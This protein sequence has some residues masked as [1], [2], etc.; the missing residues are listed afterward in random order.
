M[1]AMSLTRLSLSRH[2]LWRARKHKNNSSVASDSPR[3]DVRTERNSVHLRQ[4]KEF[5]ADADFGALA[6]RVA[7]VNSREWNP[8]GGRGCGAAKAQQQR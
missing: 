2:L 1:A 6:D 4:S 5:I 7:D 3:F 8:F